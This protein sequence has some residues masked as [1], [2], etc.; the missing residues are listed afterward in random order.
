MYDIMFVRLHNIDD[1]R[2]FKL[3]EMQRLDP[4]DPWVVF[5]REK[6]EDRKARERIAAEAADETYMA[7]LHRRY[8]KQV[9]VVHRLYEQLVAGGTNVIILSSNDEDGCGND[10]IDD[11]GGGG[12]GPNPMIG[13]L[14]K[15]D[16]KKLT[17]KTNI[18]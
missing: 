2:N 17:E 3:G 12:Q 10:D 8:P 5:A 9:E 18:D 14:T 16:W 11:D 7:E 4:V 15:G 6:R 1:H 13:G